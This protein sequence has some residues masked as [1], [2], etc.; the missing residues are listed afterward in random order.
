MS[1]NLGNAEILLEYHKIMPNNNIENIYKNMF[2]DAA[3]SIRNGQFDCGRAY[4]YGHK[5]PGFMTGMAA[6]GYE[7][8]K[9]IMPELP[10]VL[11]GEI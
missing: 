2:C 5:I 1:C 6:M 9:F 7:L 8:L 10:C 3:I 4:L 11:S